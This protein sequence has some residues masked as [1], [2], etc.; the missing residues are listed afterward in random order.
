[1]E[2]HEAYKL[3]LDLLQNK[4]RITNFELLEKMK[5]DASLLQRV[6]QELILQ[7][8]AEDYKNVGLIQV[9]LKPSSIS[10][11]L[12]NSRQPFGN[13]ITTAS[14]THRNIRIFISYGRKG[15]GLALAE[16]LEH[17]LSLKGYDVYRDLH[18]DKGLKGG[19]DFEWEIEKE[20]E[21][22]A[23]FLS[24]LTCHAVRRPDG[25][26]LDEISLARSLQK[27]IIP[28][29][30]ENSEN[31]R[32]CRPPLCIH[33]LNF[34]D[35]QQWEYEYDTRF[36]E[37]LRAIQTPQQYDGLSIVLLSF[38]GESNTVEYDFT[39]ELSRKAK[40]F[41]GRAWLTEQVNYWL[42]STDDQIFL[43]TG[44]PGSGKSAFIAHLALTHP[45]AKA[46]HFFIRSWDA[47][48]K[49]GPFLCSLASMI[50]SQIPDYR[51]VL[52]PLLSKPGFLQ[53][54]SGDLLWDLI[55][56]PLGKVCSDN[57]EPVFIMLDAID[58]S[59]EHNQ[60]EVVNLL[61]EG[62]RERRIPSWIKFLISSR[63]VPLVMTAFRGF[64]TWDIS[65]TKPEKNIKDI[66]QYLDNILDSRSLLEVLLR[67]NIEENKGKLIEEL[68]TL[69]EGN[70]LYIWLVLED[71]RK[72]LIDPTKPEF[73]PSGLPDYYTRNFE[74][75]FPNIDE[76]YR[77]CRKVLDVIFASREP[78][79]IGEIAD[80]LDET[81]TSVN[82]ILEPIIPFLELEGEVK[83]PRFRPFHA[84]FTDWI[85]RDK[86]S[87]RESVRY[88]VDLIMGHQII[89]SYMQ[90]Q[91]SAGKV[92]K[93]AL[94][95][96]PYHLF[97]AKKFEGYSALLLNAQFI[98]DK[99][100]RKELG[101]Q[102]LIEDYELIERG[103]TNIDKIPVN[104]LK[105]LTLVCGAL[106]LSSHILAKNP[107]E[108]ATQLYGRLKDSGVPVV[109]HFLKQIANLQVTPWLMPLTASFIQPGGPLVRILQGH[110]DWV[111]AVAVTPDGCHAI[112][113]SEMAFMSSD[114][115]MWVWDLATGSCI[116]TLQ[117]H[118]GH[119]NAIT[120]T[121]DGRFVVSGSFDTTIRIWELESGKSVQVLKGH[122][123]SVNAIAV[124]P[125]SRFVVSASSDKTLRVWDLATGACIQTFSGHNGTVSAIAV[126]PDGQLAISGSDDN[127]LKVWDLET[128]TCTQTLIEHSNRVTAVAVTPNGQLAISGSRDKTLKVWDLTT[129]LC[130][131]TLV[132]HTGTVSTVAVTPDGCHAISGSFDSTLKMWNLMTGVCIQTLLGHTNK[133]MA[134]ALTSDGCLAVSGSWDKTLKVWDLATDRITKKF[135]AHTNRVTAV[136]VTPNGTRAVSGSDDTSLKVWDLATGRC[137]HTLL[138]HS[139]E[140]I[141]VTVTPDSRR[142]ISGSGDKTLR[143]WDLETGACIQNLQGHTNRVWAVAVTPDGKRAISGS[144]D[145]TLRVWDLETGACIQTLQGHT[146]AVM[147]MTM[148]PD[149]SDIISGSLDKT[150]KVW[151]LASGKCTNTFMGHTSG[152]WA[153][154]MTPDGSDIIS[155]SYDQT[156]RVWNL[157]SGT[158]T[159]ILKGHTAG[160]NAVAITPD[161]RFAVSG[162]DDQMLKVWDLAQFSC[163]KTF[164]WY[165]P[166]H[167]GIA[168]SV[169]AIAVTSD[170]RHIISGSF[171]STLR[172]W[173]LESGE[174]VIV[175]HGDGACVACGTSYPTAIISG[176]DSGR[177]H[178]VRLE[179]MQQGLPVVT[180]TKRADGLV[181]I[182]CI[183]CQQWS[184]Q[185]LTALGN[186]IACPACGKKVQ[187]NL[188]TYKSGSVYGEKGWSTLKT[189]TNFFSNGLVK[190]ENNK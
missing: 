22:R 17:D 186:E 84:S 137:T 96:L 85:T 160:I 49:P 8:L 36:A 116:Q 62:I 164:Q 138:G 157:E 33:R 75:L 95:Y 5:G 163:T 121:P 92:S 105:S 50:A 111:N 4:K 99:I 190:H 70:F 68:I 40:N 52:N 54:N 13:N 77:T 145:K 31:N 1:M 169:I 153:M 179:N 82:R 57:H 39:G 159:Q 103:T 148:T 93:Y 119:I 78:L 175:I 97:Q 18:T 125:D 178:I 161:G 176:E 20:I 98:T 187:V 6:R 170:G 172:V 10:N 147:A 150:L 135:Q 37:L 177:V 59:I 19:V 189:I 81:P 83:N 102:S 73:F 9:E 32:S 141:V 143:V 173:D 44:D 108:L 64:P 123:N 114:N 139:R 155:G 67:F 156:L 184:D 127:T 134:V 129:G 51:D 149:G 15:R 151:D 21:N 166:L 46:V 113:G 128:G 69:S 47:T 14:E 61:I 90:G 66:H 11:S 162:S 7:N 34:I 48:R 79:T 60:S 43:L 106:R 165:Y 152:V 115:T 131:Q 16:R 74:R 87:P 24:L 35:Y 144:H 167:Q 185:P 181:W 107:D 45:E 100:G 26:C 58:E 27:K 136:T 3:A 130:A 140:V 30:V 28:L 118:T 171:D 86:A 174:C 112:S 188:F 120:V 88:Q 146:G 56:N 126:T 29:L 180:A 42:N 122:M 2:Y 101:I 158:C 25:Y 124:T 104:T 182:Q 76:Y 38:G 110:T 142:A 89:A 72:G 154:A 23:V 117:G 94:A 12:E 55:I 53:K 91:Y 109:D 80:I 133:V 132:G 183:F 71:I 63:P 41:T 65:H 168:G